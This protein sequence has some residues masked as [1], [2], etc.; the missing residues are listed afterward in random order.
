MN[1]DESFLNEFLNGSD[2]DDTIEIL[3][4][5]RAR[6]KQNEQSASSRKSRS[7]IDRATLEGH[8][9]LFKDYFATIPV[10]SSQMFRRRFRMSRE[11]FM[12]IHSRVEAHEPYFQQKRNS[13]GN[14]GLSSL[15]K[16]TVALRILCYGVAAD[17]MDEYIRIGET[18]TI[19]SLRYFVQSIID[20]FGHVYLRKLNSEDIARLLQIGKVRGFP[21][22]LGSIDCMH[23]RWKNCPTAWKGMF[24]GHCHEP[25]IILKAV[26]S[27]DLWIWHAF[28]GLPGSHNDIN[29]LERSHVFS[30]ITSGEGY[31]V[32]YSINGHNYNMWYYLAD[33]IYPPW[34]TFVKSIPLPM[35]RKTKHF[36]A[37]QESARKDVER[38]FSVLQARFAIVRGPARYFDRDTLNKI[39]MACIIMHNIIVEDEREL[40]PQPDISEYE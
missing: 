40:H 16:I 35:N 34:A 2:D 11:L 31:P 33:G 3:A 7:Y 12:R 28:F 24:T 19:K 25:T 22:M 39:M 14:L 4:L 13:A 1:S 10:Y 5:R 21:G 9:R 37:A 20:I 23:W 27:Y 6:K 29:V 38:A 30:E 8:N 26:A 18:T 15:Q 36:T 32:D 17:F